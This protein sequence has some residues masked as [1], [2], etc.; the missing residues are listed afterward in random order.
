LYK[1]PNIST[2]AGTCKRYRSLVY[3]QT[4]VQNREYP[5]C[6]RRLYE[7]ENINTA[8]K[9]RLVQRTEA[10]WQQHT[11]VVDDDNDR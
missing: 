1:N 7:G 4:L 10:E 11:M 2:V 5:Y 8:Q 6:S 3:Q 9:E